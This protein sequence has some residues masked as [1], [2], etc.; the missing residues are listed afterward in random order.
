MMDRDRELHEM[1]DEG[2]AL[3][4]YGIK[5]CWIKKEDAVDIVTYYYGKDSCA[6]DDIRATISEGDIISVVRC[7]DC[8]HFNSETKNTGI[9]DGGF[10]HAPVHVAVIDFCSNGERKD[11]E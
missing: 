6:V 3:T 2:R 5:D 11:D 10:C 7:K 4:R 8:K 9:C 1:A